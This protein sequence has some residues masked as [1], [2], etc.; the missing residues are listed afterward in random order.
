MK[1]LIVRITFF[2]CIVISQPLF[3]KIVYIHNDVL[4][5]P[6]MRTD[7]SG[8]VISRAH[9]KPFGET[10][11]AAKNDVGYTGHLNDTDLGLSYMQARYYDP[12][13]GR[14][15]SNDPIGFRDVHSFNRYAYANNNPYKY[16]DPTG[17]LAVPWHGGIS[18]FAAL[19]SGHSFG[20]SLSIAY[21]AMQADWMP[22]SQGD[23]KFATAIHA[24]RA[25]KQSL[26]SAIA[27]NKAVI[28]GAL[29][30]GDLGLAGHAIQ[31]GVVH[32]FGGWLGS[33]KALGFSGAMKHLWNDIFPSFSKISTAYQL[34]KQAYTGRSN[35]GNL[36]NP[37]PGSGSSTGGGVRGYNGQ[38]GVSCGWGGGSP[39]VNRHENNPIDP[40]DSHGDRI[41]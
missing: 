36:Y 24:M 34:T 37:F 15:Y 3:A 33:F 2:L 28:K 19:N 35:S 40:R 10:L 27:M 25:D 29:D 26:G 23:S 4:G 8:H 20:E 41:R 17:G 11:K 14:F 21:R 38:C 13:I 32:G 18:F 5:S 31:D 6:I 16:V 1:Q 7:E 9:Y 30:V 22:G 12:V 39:P